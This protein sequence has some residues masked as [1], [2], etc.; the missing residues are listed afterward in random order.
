MKTSAQCSGEVE[1]EVKNGIEK[2]TAKDFM[3][4]TSIACTVRFSSFQ[5][6]RGTERGTKRG[7]KDGQRLLCEE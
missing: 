4:A 2:G 1:W 5:K 6:Q 7:D 3:L